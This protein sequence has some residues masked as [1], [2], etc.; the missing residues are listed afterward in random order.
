MRFTMNEHACVIDCVR[1][2]DNEGT[3]VTADNFAE[4]V[5]DMLNEHC[6]A[7]VFEAGDFDIVEKAETMPADEI[8]ALL[9]RLPLRMR[10]HI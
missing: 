4:V 8:A 5:F 1:R 7:S 9:D 6:L 3:L 10:M 2:A